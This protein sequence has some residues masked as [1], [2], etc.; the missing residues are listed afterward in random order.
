V[1]I[2]P[3]TGEKALFVNPGFTKRIEGLKEEESDALLKLL[4]AVRFLP[5]QNMTR[6]SLDRCEKLADSKFYSISPTVR[7]YRSA[8]SGMTKL[9][10]SGTTESRLI[11][12]F[13]ITT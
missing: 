2:H 5:F 6:P 12:Q 11:L 1:R 4:F 13:R 7:T 3:A 9:L 8:S 10:R